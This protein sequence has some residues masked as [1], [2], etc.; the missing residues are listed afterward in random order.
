MNAFHRPDDQDA[1]HGQS[2]DGELHSCQEEERRARAEARPRDQGPLLAMVR[3]C[4]LRIDSLT[5]NFKYEVS[6]STVSKEDMKKEGGFDVALAAAISLGE[7]IPPSFDRIHEQRPEH[8]QSKRLPR[9]HGARERG[10]DA[11][12]SAAALGGP[13]ARSSRDDIEIPWKRLGRCCPTSSR[14]ADTT[15]AE[16]TEAILRQVVWQMQP[17]RHRAH[18]VDRHAADLHGAEGE[19]LG[20]AAMGLSDLVVQ[21]MTVS[22][23][24]KKRAGPDSRAGSRGSCGGPSGA[25]RA[26]RAASSGLRG[27]TRRTPS[28]F[29]STWPMRRAA[30]SSEARSIRRRPQHAL[31]DARGSEARACSEYGCR[32]PDV[33]E[34]QGF[35]ASSR[36]LQESGRQSLRQADARSDRALPGQPRAGTRRRRRASDPARGL[37]LD[38][39]LRE[40]NGPS[41]VD[42]ARAVRTGTTPGAHLQATR[43]RG[44]SETLRRVRL[45]AGA[46]R[47]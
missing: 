25:S 28:A 42:W 9:H 5:V 16:A 12:W 41:P 23:V 18:R 29:G 1:H 8:D 46:Y 31:H 3:N 20:D 7:G 35:L 47:R 6:Q 38:L 24:L 15:F 11:R 43:A 45:P 26:P 14:S 36:L 33:T 32:G 37:P 19:W 27:R 13:L 40:G 34:W 17:Q 4:H 30:A 39:L 22:F 2:L 10:R 44:S 21:D